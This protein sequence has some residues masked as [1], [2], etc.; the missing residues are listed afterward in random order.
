M[1]AIDIAYS[2]IESARQS[3]RTT[4]IESRLQLNVMDYARETIE[5]EFDVVLFNSSLHHFKDIPAILDKVKSNL[6]PGGLLLLN[7]YVGPD[8]FQWTDEQLM[9]INDLL[10]SIPGRYRRIFRTRL[11]K[12][13]VWKPGI[14]RMI[15]NDPSEA[16][17]SSIILEHVHKRFSILEEKGLGGNLLM[18]LLKDISHN[19]LDN[20]P[21]T[22]SLLASLIEKEDEYIRT[23]RSNFVFGVYARN[24]Y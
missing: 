15:V 8:R 23:V 9:L 20:S 6:V 4:S 1:L 7:E 3:V 24:D 5:G 13:K 11:I 2:Q 21:Q 10:A 17:H 18:P 12:S 22:H 19:F 16:P 14:L